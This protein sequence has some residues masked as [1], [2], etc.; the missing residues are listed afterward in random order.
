MG[1]GKRSCEVLVPDGAPRLSLG[2][3]PDSGL[4]R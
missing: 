4:V 3:R 1:I 2:Q